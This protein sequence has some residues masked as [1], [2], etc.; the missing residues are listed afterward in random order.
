VTEPRP[1]RLLLVE[2][3]DGD[4]LIVSELLIDSGEHIETDRVTSVGA[5]LPF[6]DKVDCALVDLGL[7][8]AN[9][10][11]ALQSLRSHGPELAIVVL[12]GLTGRTRGVESL[13]EGAQDYLVKGEVDGPQ[14]ARAI[15]YAVERKRTERSARLLLLSERRQDEND[16]LARGLLPHLKPPAAISVATRY[17][18]GADATLGGDFYDAWTT[19]GRTLRAV[20]G[21]VCGHGP[22]EAALGVA[23]RIAWRSHTMAGAG[24]AE[25]LAAMERVL[26]AERDAREPYA[27]VCDIIIDLEAETLT[28]RLHGHPPPLLLEPAPHWQTGTLPAPPLGIA[29]TH[30]AAP[31]STVR[32]DPGWQLLLLTDGLYEGRASAGRLGADGLIELLAGHDRTRSDGALLD[33]LVADVQLLNGGDLD[34]DLAVVWLADGR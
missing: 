23:L 14:L 29:D 27:T 30:L 16:R 4:A 12:T 32:L 33:D 11:A 3:D 6:I 31:P 7:P 18:P 10:L 25:T 15:R 26:V 5:A 21:D 28:T 2:D 13:A 1:I 9:G 17:R 22:A 19:D 20:I 24:A 8:D 34:D